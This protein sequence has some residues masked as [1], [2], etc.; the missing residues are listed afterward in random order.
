[1]E[2]NGTI[3]NLNFNINIGE[4]KNS[5]CTCAID[6]GRRK[7]NLTDMEGKTG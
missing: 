1:M 3:I 2:N 4:E 6:S 5:F 7:S